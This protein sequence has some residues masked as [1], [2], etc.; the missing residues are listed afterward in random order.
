MSLP[1]LVTIVCIGLA[2]QA[3]AESPNLGV[4]VDAET[5]AGMDYTVLPDGDGLP[6]GT[7]TAREGAGVFEAHCIACHGVDGEGSVNDALVGGRGGI[8]RALWSCG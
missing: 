3:A 6:T 5:L 8:Q 4:P 1:R 7:G 2:L